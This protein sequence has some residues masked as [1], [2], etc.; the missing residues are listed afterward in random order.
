MDFGD[1]GQANCVILGV[2]NGEA[3]HKRYIQAIHKLYMS[4]TATLLL[5]ALFYRILRA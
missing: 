1:V 5:N 3:I 4:A 2:S